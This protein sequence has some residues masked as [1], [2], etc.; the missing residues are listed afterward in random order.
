MRPRKALRKLAAERLAAP[1]LVHRNYLRI[2]SRINGTDIDLECTRTVLLGAQ[3]KSATRMQSPKQGLV[4]QVLPVTYSLFH[5]QR[6]CL[7][8]ERLI[9]PRRKDWHGVRARGEAQT[10]ARGCGARCEHR[11][12][13]G[14]SVFRPA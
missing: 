3:T 13:A 11:E 8:L 5:L 12:R 4:S 6:E 7:L 1:R 14:Q 10:S 9:P 2:E